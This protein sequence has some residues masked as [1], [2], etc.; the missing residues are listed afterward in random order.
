MDLSDAPDEAQFRRNLR[1]W[2]EKSLP[3]LPWP[4]PA[5]LGREGAVLEAVAARCST[6]PVTPGCPGPASTAEGLGA[7]IA[8]DLRRGARS[9]RERPERL[10]TIGEDFAGPTVADFGT[11]CAERAL[12]P[13]DPRPARRSGAS[14]SPNPSRG[15][16]SPRCAPK[17]TKVDGA[18]GGS[19]G[20]KIWT[21]RAQLA[22]HAILLAA[23]GRRSPR[24]KGITYF[25]LPLDTEGVTVRP[26]AHMLGEAEFN[27]VFLDEVFLPDSA[28]SSARS[29]G[30][31]PSPWRPSPTSGS[32]SRPAE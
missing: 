18:A 10:N 17:A 20:Q 5:E 29:T 4:E 24:H 3:E 27:E 30:A 19:T 22:A 23:H 28:S 21:S 7:R 26:L 12:P 9:A 2:L 8:D 16:T 6:T 31:G 14:S 15:P 32:R 1:T 13:P 25:L 11:D